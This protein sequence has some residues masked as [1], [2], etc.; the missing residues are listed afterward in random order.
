MSNAKIGMIL[1]G[2]VF[3][4]SLFLKSTPLVISSFIFGWLIPVVGALCDSGN[5]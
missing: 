4:G 2:I 1:W 5:L 3:I